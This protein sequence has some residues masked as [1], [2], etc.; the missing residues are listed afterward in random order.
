MSIAHT[1]RAG[2]IPALSPASSETG[3][4][5][6]LPDAL[7]DHA[8]EIV[9]LLHDNRA[10]ADVSGLVDVAAAADFDAVVVPTAIAA[11]LGADRAVAVPAAVAA[12]AEFDALGR[13]GGGAEDTKAKSEGKVLHRSIS[14]GFR[15]VQTQR[16]NARSVP[17]WLWFSLVRPTL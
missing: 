16:F 14:Q 9:F 11:H 13:G 2:E 15:L 7:R 17:A 1:K 4:V 12:G 10:A 3:S 5:V 6:A 8:A